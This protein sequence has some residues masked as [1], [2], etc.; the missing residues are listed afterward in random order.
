MDEEVLTV[1]RVRRNLNEI[2]KSWRAS[3]PDAPFYSRQKLLGGISAAGFAF[4]FVLSHHK[5]R[6]P[7]PKGAPPP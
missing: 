2:R 5:H 6:A 4:R 1:A 3:Q 7:P